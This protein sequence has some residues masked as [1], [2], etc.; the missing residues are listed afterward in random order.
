MSSK[1]LG[2]LMYA[3]VIAVA[4]CGLMI[5]LLVVPAVGRDIVLANPEFS[6]WFWPWLVFVWLFAL[7]CFGILVYVWKVSGAVANE[8]VFTVR[9]AG[10]V[11]MG[12][13]LMFAAAVI[14]LV[15]NVVL[16]WLGM[17]HFGVLLAWIVADIFAF[18]L[19]LLVGVLS[20][21]L[22]RAA[23]LQEESEGTL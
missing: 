4:L 16:A 14:A 11:R 22:V 21:Y 15:G 7:P 10:W 17:H 2:R 6:G 1:T 9:T 19:A 5:C 23:E 3:S 12:S 8:A 18:T 13:L 20:R